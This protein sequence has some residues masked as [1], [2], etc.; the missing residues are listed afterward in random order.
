MQV[1]KEASA[2]EGTR[3]AI[4]SNYP[5]DGS[6][7]SNDCE[8]W[9][10]GRAT[11]A[12]PTFLDP[13]VIRDRTYVDG[14]IK[15]NNPTEV[16]LQ[17]AQRQFPGRKIGTIVSL[18]CGLQRKQHVSDGFFAPVE[19]LVNAASSCENVHSSLLH[20]LGVTAGREELEKVYRKQQ[21]SFR[22]THPMVVSPSV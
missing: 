3:Q 8:L 21:L 19:T 15:A 5:R 7:Q 6:P 1:T 10:A 2:A 12:A 17:E 18:G 14:G 20:G 16:A 4:F 11:G 13:M 9:E 22:S